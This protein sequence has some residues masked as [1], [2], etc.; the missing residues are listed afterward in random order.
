VRVVAAAIVIL[1]YVAIALVPMIAMG[2]T[3]LTV[4]QNN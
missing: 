4:A 2:L 1:L 3:V